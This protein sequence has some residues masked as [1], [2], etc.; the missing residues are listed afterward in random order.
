MFQYRYRFLYD[1]QLAEHDLTTSSPGVKAVERQGKGGGHY[2]QYRVTNPDPADQ[3]NTILKMAK[4]RAM[5][6]AALSVG[7]LSEIFTQDVEDMPRDSKTNDTTVTVDQGNA[8]SQQSSSQYHCAQH[9]T[10]WF[11]TERMRGYAHKIEGTNPLQWC[12][13]PTEAPNGGNQQRTAEQGGSTLRSSAQ[14]ANAWLEYLG[15]ETGDLVAVTQ[16]REDADRMLGM[17]IKLFREHNRDMTYDQIFKYMTDQWD[18]E[19][20]SAE[21]PGDGDYSLPSDHSVQEMAEGLQHG[22]D[23]QQESMEL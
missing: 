3:V 7:R 8:R 11:K 6:D 1:R 9:D 17:D 16:A 2:T 10:D 15:V 19:S 5:V 21:H 20:M 14:I 22:D 13:M 23:Q 12:N 18:L 4:K